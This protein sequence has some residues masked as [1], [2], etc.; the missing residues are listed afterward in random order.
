VTKAMI[1]I[2]QGMLFWKE[3]CTYQFL[4]PCE[5]VEK[6]YQKRI[7]RITHNTH[8]EELRYT[9]LQEPIK[10]NRLY[11]S[12]ARKCYADARYVEYNY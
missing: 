8:G 4:E 9:V 1:G 7:Y 11:W 2:F 10:T 6:E 12:N 3:D 5:N